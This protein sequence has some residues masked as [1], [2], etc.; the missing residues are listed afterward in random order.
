MAIGNSKYV[1]KHYAST[2]EFCDAHYDEIRDMFAEFHPRA[3]LAGVGFRLALEWHR[4]PHSGA[5]HGVEYY[6]PGQWRPRSFWGGLA[7]LSP[8]EWQ[9]IE[10]R[11]REKEAQKAQEA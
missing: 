10:R 2:L 4:S 11:I 7:Y 8:R 3:H 6:A 1:K 9:T 5:F